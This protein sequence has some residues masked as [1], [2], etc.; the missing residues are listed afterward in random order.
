[1]TLKAE[2]ITVEG[3][4]GGLR[5]IGVAL[6]GT[7]MGRLV[8]APGRG[9]PAVVPAYSPKDIFR[10]AYNLASQSVRRRISEFTIFSPKPIDSSDGTAGIHQRYIEFFRNL[11]TKFSPDAV[12]IVEGSDEVEEL[13]TAA[14][15]GLPPSRTR[16]VSWCSMDTMDD[17]SNEALRSGRSAI[18]LGVADEMI[19]RTN[20]EARGRMAVVCN[21]ARQALSYFGL[22]KCNNARAGAFPSFQSRAE[23]IAVRTSDD[24]AWDFSGRGPWPCDIPVGN[25]RSPFR[26]IS[27]IKTVKLGSASDYRLLHDHEVEGARK[28]HHLPPGQ[29]RFQ[30]LIL[31]AP[32]PGNIRSNSKDR[33]L[34]RRA[35]DTLARWGIPVAVRG[36]ATV[37]YKPTLAE[38]EFPGDV[39]GNDAGFLG[40]ALISARGMAE[41]ESTVVMQHLVAKTIADGKKGEELVDIVGR[42]FAS[43]A[44]Y[45]MPKVGEAEQD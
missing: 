2:N 30:G 24:T 7:P 5:V 37:D 34:L 3:P 14:Q 40:G 9:V 8:H 18:E 39:Y 23:P 12:I 15:I 42:R 31:A 16:W 25:V 33:S 11:L 17:E 36:R 41:G 6:G 13:V 45:F 28:E 4:I 26:L 19:D 29:K 20:G 21:D 22:T 27:G 1:M 32:G 44:Q 43:Y 38:G 10:A 35:V